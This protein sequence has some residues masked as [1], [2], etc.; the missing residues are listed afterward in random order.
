MIWLLKENY[1]AGVYVGKNTAPLSCRLE[2]GV[3]LNTGQ[4]MLIFHGDA[5]MRRVNEIINHVVEICIHNYWVSLRN[6]KFKLY[7]R[8]IPL[9]NRLMDITALTFIT[10]NLLLPCFDWLVSKCSLFSCRGVV[11]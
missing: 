5:L 11:Q 6:N 9:L 1:S 8:K 3:V 4:T 10:F 2:D 7:S